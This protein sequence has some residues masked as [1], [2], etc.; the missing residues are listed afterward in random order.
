[1]RVQYKMEEQK[2]YPIYISR[3]KKSGRGRPFKPMPCKYKIKHGLGAINYNEYLR[4]ET[5]MT[6]FYRSIFP[7]KGERLIAY[8]SVVL[9]WGRPRINKTVGIPTSQIL[10]VKQKI[11]DLKYLWR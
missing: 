10:K 11:K 4:T 9:R 7:N 5:T 8:C 3:P 6:D 2:P 1:M